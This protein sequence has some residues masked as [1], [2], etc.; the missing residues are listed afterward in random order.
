MQ[1]TSASAAAVAAAVLALPLSV[2]AAAATLSST[3]G[4]T[5]TSGTPLTYQVVNK[6][7]IVS[8]MMMGLINEETVLIIDKVEANQYTFP[9]GKVAFTSIFNP[10]TKEVKPLEANS[11]PF[12]A[13]GAVLGNGSWAVFGGNHNVNG[14][15]DADD[16]AAPYLTVDGRKSIRFVD[17]TTNFASVSVID[18]GAQQMA[19]QRWYPGIEVLS[20]GDVFLIGG[21]TWGGYI[22]RVAGQQSREQI[23]ANAGQNPTYEYFPPRANGPQQSN[24]MITTVGEYPRACDESEVDG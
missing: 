16:N 17:P 2:L 5:V 13:S 7:S 20:T 10:K 19:T 23:L 18:N 21:S 4:P 12:C 9:D 15:G 6:N 3:G 1:I 8:A 14:T 22:N 24:F 11:N